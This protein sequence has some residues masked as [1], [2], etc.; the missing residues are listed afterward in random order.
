[1]P[2][3]EPN[4]TTSNNSNLRIGALWTVRQL[5]DYLQVTEQTIR[6]L[7]KRGTIPALKIGRA[8]RFRKEDIEWYLEG[9]KSETLVK[10]QGDH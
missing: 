7:A 1:M 5:A 10:D 2:Y 6:T 4:L 3:S 8:W 9:G